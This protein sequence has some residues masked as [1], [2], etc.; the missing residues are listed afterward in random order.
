MLIKEGNRNFRGVVGRGTEENLG[1]ARKVDS[2]QGEGD[3]WPG[4]PKEGYVAGN[5]NS[6]MRGGCEPEETLA[7]IFQ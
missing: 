4:D 7:L 3:L 5:Q 1:P 2:E 6:L